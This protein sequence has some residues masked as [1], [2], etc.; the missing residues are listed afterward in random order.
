MP[1]ITPS[2]EDISKNKHSSTEVGYDRTRTYI[3]IDEISKERFSFVLA[4][5]GMGKSRLLKQIV[6]QSSEIFQ[7]SLYIEAKYLNGKDYEKAINKILARPPGDLLSE[8]ELV[9]KKN[10]FFEKPFELKKDSAFL[11]CL[12][13]LDEVGFD[14]IG[15]HAEQ[16]DELRY[17]YP[18]AHIIVSCRDY[19]HKRIQDRFSDIPVKLFQL[20]PFNRFS[21]EEFLR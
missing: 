14:N 20:N 7:G 8:Q 12:D 13:A 11:V 9:A 1:Y 16:L 6:K 10:S 21:A 4:M 5:P 18:K 17:N 3:K 2:I 15:H 19:I